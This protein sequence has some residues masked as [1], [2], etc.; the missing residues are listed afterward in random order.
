[1]G[2]RSVKRITGFSVTPGAHF[3]PL[4]EPETLPRVVLRLCFTCVPPLLLEA[5]EELVLDDEEKME[6]SD[7]SEGFVGGIEMIVCI[8]LLEVL[9]ILSSF[10]F[11][12][13]ALDLDEEEELVD[14]AGGAR[15]LSFVSFGSLGFRLESDLESDFGDDLEPDLEASDLESDLE[16]DFEVLPV[17]EDATVSLGEEESEAAS[18]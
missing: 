16:S 1:M 15:E 10:L 9:V 14:E 6:K 8:S 17:G 3:R 7:G 2:Q 18:G 12:S 5:L 4:S 11:A 13:A